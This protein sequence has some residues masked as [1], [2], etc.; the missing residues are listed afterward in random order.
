[1]VS[2]SATRKD[3]LLPDDLMILVIISLLPLFVEIFFGML[4]TIDAGALF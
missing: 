2:I 3:F 4:G 1:M